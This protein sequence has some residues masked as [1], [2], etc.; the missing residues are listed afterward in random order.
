MSRRFTYKTNVE[1]SCGDEGGPDFDIE[2]SFIVTG[3]GPETPPS[4]ASGG[5]PAEDAE[6]DDIRLEKVDGKPRPWGMYD[7]YVKDEDAEFEATI[8]QILEHQTHYEAML[9]SAGEDMAADR[10][11]AAEQRYEADRDDR[12]A[13]WRD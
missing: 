9:L 6:I 3:G 13:G 1:V 2:V 4:Y 10:D 12:A 8:V 5:S 7:G 11:E